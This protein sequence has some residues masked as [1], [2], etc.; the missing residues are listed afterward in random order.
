MGRKK[1]IF[2]TFLIFAEIDPES[3]ENCFSFVG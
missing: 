3:K 2:A 1:A